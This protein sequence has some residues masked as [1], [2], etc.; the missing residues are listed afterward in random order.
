MIKAG[1]KL[2]VPEKSSESSYSPP[3]FPDGLAPG[4]SA[5][6]AKSLQKALKDTG[7]LDRSVPLSDVYGP[8]TQ[9]AVVGFN[10]KHKLFT[11]GRPQDPAIGRRGWNLLHELA[12][13]K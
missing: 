5:P 2:T 7:W 9:K 3:P 8:Q 1:Q 6:S 12:Y 4:R 10:R 13:G 11:S